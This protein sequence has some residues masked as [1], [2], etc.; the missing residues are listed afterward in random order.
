MPDDVDFALYS[1]GFLSPADKDLLAGLP[2]MDPE[3]LGQIAPVFDDPRYGELLFRYRARNFLQSLTQA[4]WQRWQKIRR[5]KLKGVGSLKTSVKRI[6][7][8]LLQLSQ[9]G[10]LEHY[11]IEQLQRFA[12]WLD[13]QPPV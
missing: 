7:D 3:A 9:R 8:E 10:D 11:Q 4:E 12:A 5:D 13:H 1:G 2:L 6:E